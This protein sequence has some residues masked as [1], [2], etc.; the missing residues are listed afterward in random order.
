[1]KTLVSAVVLNKLS[2]ILFPLLL[3]YF[4]LFFFQRIIVSF[5]VRCGKQML[6]DFIFIAVVVGV[7]LL[8]CFLFLFYFR[9]LLLV[10]LI[11]LHLLLKF[12]FNCC[13]NNKQEIVRLELSVRVVSFVVVCVCVFVF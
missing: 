10:F 13:S 5:P 2:R 1:M 8:V 12:L 3:F 7:C 6:C 11:P 9:F 4:C